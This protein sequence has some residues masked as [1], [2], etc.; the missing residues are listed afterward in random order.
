MNVELESVP[1]QIGTAILD[2]S[3]GKILRSSGDLASEE[4]TTVCASIFRLLLDTSKCLGSEPMRRLSVTF[5][6][7][8]YIVT[9][10]DK[11]IYIV[12]LEKTEGV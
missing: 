3:D 9:L 6:D 7:H 5:S 4:A 12:K 10:G 8:S 2:V 11:N 1:S